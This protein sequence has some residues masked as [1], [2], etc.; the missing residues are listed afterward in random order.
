LEAGS[1]SFAL[2]SRFL[3]RRAADRA[4]VLYAWCR[5]ADD[6]VDLCPPGQG[7][8]AVERLR[9]ELARIEEGATQSDPLL[10]AFAEVLRDC[11]IPLDYPRALLDGM[12]RD[13]A[14]AGYATLG[15]L[16]GYCYQVAG[17]VGLMMSHALGVRDPRALRQGVHLGIAMQLTNVCR[18]VAE[19]WRL[20]RLYLPDELCAQA[21]VPDLRSRLGA[22]LASPGDLPRAEIA[23]VVRRLLAEA[24][25]YY[26]SGD[27][28][29]WALPW[30]AGL[31]IRAARS[32]YAQIGVQ[33]GRE[34]FDP[35]RGRAVVG[36]LTKT[37]LA[38]RATLRHSLLLPGLLV[39]RL[40][41]R[42]S[43]P[44]APERTLR[45]PEDVLPL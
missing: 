45:F 26:T 13:A 6:S 16:L 3:T 41:G 39:Q 27:G 33:L 25:R 28:G 5:R 12:E 36:P 18:D 29:L 10:A 22:P 31:A 43:A 14:G 23:L 19:D 20:G 40:T 32:I 42:L 8:L 4:A 35:L 9:R 7:G 38:L 11:A 17:T 34:G 37:T 21:G 44:R 30:R 24:D 15:D 1:K 2:A